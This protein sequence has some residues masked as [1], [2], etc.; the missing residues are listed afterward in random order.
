MRIAVSTPHG[1][2]GR[3]VVRDLVRA[4][5]HPLL[6]THNDRPTDPGLAPF[7]T[8]TAADLRNADDVVQALEGADAFYFVVPPSTGDDPVRDYAAA[9]EA[10]TRAVTEHGI[11]HVV[12]QSSVGAELRHGAGEIDGLALV[13]E[14]LDEATAGTQTRV[15]HLRCGFFFTNLLFQLDAIR[16]GEVPILLPVDHKLPWVAPRDIAAMAATLLLRPVSGGRQVH[17]VH[18]P[19]DLSWAEAMAILSDVTGHQVRAVRIPD[20]DMRAALAGAGLGHAQVEAMV[21]MSIGL[22]EGFVAEQPRD[23]MSTT[24]TSLASWVFECLRPLLG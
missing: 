24:E 7:V 22:R 5:L 20:D 15:T 13:E 23:A 3:H 18:G 1:N 21:G 8:R 11:P 10:A 19:R 14:M 2:V 4:G 16:G 12:L 6:L 17:A 9:G